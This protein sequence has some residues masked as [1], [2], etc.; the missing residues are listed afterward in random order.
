[1]IDHPRVL[2]ADD[3]E[4][5][6]LGIRLALER[7]GFVVCA[8]ADTADRAVE[9]ANR[10]APDLCLLDILMPGNGL[11]AAAEIVDAL[12][13]CAI[14]ILTVVSEDESLFEALR[15][16]ARGYLMKNTDSA[17]L[18]RLLRSVLAG[19]AVLPGRLAARVIEEFRQRGRG[20]RRMRIGGQ[21]VSLTAREWEVLELL[22]RGLSTEAVATKLYITPATVRNHVSAVLQKLKVKTRAEA[23]RVVAEQERRSRG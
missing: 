22:R 8:E 17:D 2:I 12:P 13:S 9:A 19:E 10:E 18:P 11:R 4:A 3:H 1:M 6:R 15:I 21:E 14:V 7:A 5:T 20:A 23:L 16:G